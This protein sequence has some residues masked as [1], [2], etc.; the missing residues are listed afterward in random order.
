MLP[1]VGRRWSCPFVGASAGRLPRS[2][3]QVKLTS[4][5]MSLRCH[6]PGGAA[7]V[8]RDTR[9][10][11]TRESSVRLQHRCNRAH[12]GAPVHVQRIMGILVVDLRVIRSVVFDQSHP[13]IIGKSEYGVH[14]DQGSA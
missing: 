2:A 13:L 3:A 14:I 8:L 4:P 6:R 7:P 9:T 5:Q 10:S 1:Y 12:I 11:S